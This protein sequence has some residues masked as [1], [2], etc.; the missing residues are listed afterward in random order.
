MAGAWSPAAWCKVSTYEPR[1]KLGPFPQFPIS[2]HVKPETLDVFALAERRLAWTGQRQAVLAQNIANAN[3]PAYT[4]RDV[5]SFGAYLAGLG[6]PDAA[7][8]PDRTVAERSL[9]GNAVSLDDQLVKVSE[10][11]TAHQL[12]MTLYKKYVTLFKTALGRG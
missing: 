6:R 3:T 4:A 10:T 11:D 7:A 1:P 12:A 8:K 5:Q 9:D 2:S